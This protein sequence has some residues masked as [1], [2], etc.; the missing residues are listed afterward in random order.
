ML[1]SNFASHFEKLQHHFAIFLWFSISTIKA[2][3]KKRLRERE[4]EERER[5]IELTLTLFFLCKS[6]RGEEEPSPL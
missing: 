3:E 4:S 1:F 2:Q 6:D 5:E